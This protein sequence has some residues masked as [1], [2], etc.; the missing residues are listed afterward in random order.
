MRILILLLVC[1]VC[2]DC[3]D[4]AED[5]VLKVDKAKT[6]L[7]TVGKAVQVS[8]LRSRK[9]PTELGLLVQSRLLPEKQT[10][11]PWG[12]PLCYE[13]SVGTKC[14][15]TP[16]TGTFSLCSSGPDKTFRTKDDICF[17][18][19]EITDDE[20]MACVRLCAFRKAG[21]PNACPECPPDRP[22]FTDCL[23]RACVDK[24]VQD[25]AMDCRR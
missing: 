21:T 1:G 8:F 7:S 23:K 22:D 2:V 17:G 13:Q 4:E 18:D 20:G 14:S 15:S 10:V 11:D 19:R 16:P 3:K 9:F 25:C 5:E 12:Q 24:F 6:Q